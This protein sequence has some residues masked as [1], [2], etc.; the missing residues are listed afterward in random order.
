[1]RI[2]LIPFGKYTNIK[3]ISRFDGPYLSTSSIQAMTAV[4]A[5]SEHPVEAMKLIELM[6]TDPHSELY[7]GISDPD[8]VIPEMLSRM[9]DAGLRKVTSEIQRQLDEFVAEK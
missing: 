6:N 4:S 8:E 5:Y 3:Y 1:M 7:T 2:R 9:E